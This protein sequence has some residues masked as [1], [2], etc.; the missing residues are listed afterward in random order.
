MG[1]DLTLNKANNITVIPQDYPKDKIAPNPYGVAKKPNHNF[2]QGYSTGDC[3]LLGGGG[4]LALTTR[5]GAEIIE[6]SVFKDSEGNTHVTLQGVGEKYIFSPRVLAMSAGNLSMGDDTIRAIELAAK[7]R[8][9]KRLEQFDS[10]KLPDKDKDKANLE[11][12]RESPITGK[13]DIDDSYRLL[14]KNYIDTVESLNWEVDAKNPELLVPK[15]LSK[16]PSL[17]EKAQKR[18]QE[19]N[20]ILN[21]KQRNPERFALAATFVM[22]SSIGTAKKGMHHGAFIESVDDTN[23]VV[24]NTW[25]TFKKYKITREQFMKEYFKVISCDLK[26]RRTDKK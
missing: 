19:V 13:Y 15:D 1:S 26:T 3:G 5:K 8:E 14:T 18:H 2:R 9:L 23:L 12:L 7:A 4:S 17:A 20:D 25:D 24:V 22:P 10:L 6:N 16:D 21:A 11:R